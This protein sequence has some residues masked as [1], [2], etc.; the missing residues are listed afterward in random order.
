PGRQRRG[1]GSSRPGSGGHPLSAST[2]SVQAEGCPHHRRTPEEESRQGRSKGRRRIGLKYVVIL[3]L[4]DKVAEGSQRRVFA[5]CKRQ[6]GSQSAELTQDF[7]GRK[8]HRV[9]SRAKE[10]QK[11][12]RQE[13]ASYHAIYIASA[14]TRACAPRFPARPSVHV[15]ACTARSATSTSR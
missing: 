12:H 7:L 13:S 6:S 14:F 2:R 15:S 4:P 9:R 11:W 10:K 8:Q 5:S 1:Q 3:K